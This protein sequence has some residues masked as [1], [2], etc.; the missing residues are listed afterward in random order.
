MKI[1]KVVTYFILRDFL[2]LLKYV[3]DFTAQNKGRFHFLGHFTEPMISQ[4]FN[5]VNNLK[6][7]KISEDKLIIN[8]V[9]KSD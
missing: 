9:Q 7:Y 1:Y 4:Y 5:I 3:Q 6:V 8:I 2:C